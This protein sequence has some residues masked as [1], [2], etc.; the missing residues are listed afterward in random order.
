MADPT[1]SAT[2]APRPDHAVLQE[3]TVGGSVNPAPLRDLA[4]IIPRASSAEVGVRG[5]LG[6]TEGYVGAGLQLRATNETPS[7][8][9]RDYFLRVNLVNSSRLLGN[10]SDRAGIWLTQRAGV[11]YIPNGETLN[12]DTSD[13]VAVGFRQGPRIGFRISHDSKFLSS[14]AT[15]P[16]WQMPEGFF[17]SYSL[18]DQAPQADVDRL[19]AR[20][21]ELTGNDGKGGTLAKYNQVVDEI[22]TLEVV[23]KRI[24]GGASLDTIAYE[25]GSLPSFDELLKTSF[26]KDAI[27]AKI[28]ALDPADPEAQRYQKLREALF[29]QKMFVRSLLAEPRGENAALVGELGGTL[30]DLLEGLNR[31]DLQAEVQDLL[32]QKKGELREMGDLPG[33]VADL[34]AAVKRVAEE[35]TAAKVPYFAA[36]MLARSLHMINVGQI[37]QGIMDIPGTRGKGILLLVSTSPIYDIPLYR[38]TQGLIEN[39]EPQ[40]ARVAAL[41]IVSGIG[42]YQLQAGIS[43]D[44]LDH[45]GNGLILTTASLRATRVTFTGKRSHDDLVQLALTG[46][47]SLGL[48]ALGA[49]QVS[50]QDSKGLGY[51]TFTVAANN[52]IAG[53]TL[54]FSGL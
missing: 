50:Q 45:Y 25:G 24:Q 10:P 4:P 51:R 23:D 20:L 39:L 17:V 18:E 22:K 14:D 5:R 8:Q 38:S 53:V 35:N 31:S 32:E 34:Q 44:A 1:P 40:W 12:T 3:V 48:G 52:A 16:N 46:L 47:I 49:Y 54:K 36:D 6:N 33:E 9:R 21:V 7:D 27:D 29:T 15:A 19:N 13:E 42:I 37:S 11:Q 2:T 41:V 30:Q 43:H 26:L 28:S